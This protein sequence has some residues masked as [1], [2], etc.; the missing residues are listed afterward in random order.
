MN[1]CRAKVCVDIRAA[2]DTIPAQFI[3]TTPD[4]GPETT[5]S[6]ADMGTVVPCLLRG[7]EEGAKVDMRMNH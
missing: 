2:A 3:S 7:A 5:T 4:A 6:Y 1:W